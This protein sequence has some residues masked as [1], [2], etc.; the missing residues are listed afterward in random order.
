[1]KKRGRLILI[2]S[3]CLVGVLMGL[4]ASAEKGTQK[5]RGSYSIFEETMVDLSWPEV[6]QAA[7]DGAII[8]FPTAVIE[9]HGPHM[10]IGV[11]TYEAYMKCKLLRRELE[12]RGIY[13]LIAPPFYWGI[14]VAT[15]AW[16]GSFTSRPSTVQAVLFDALASLRKWG[17]LNVFFINFHG[18]K[19]H[20]LAICNAI[21]EARSATGVKAYYPMRLS[22]ARP[23]GLTAKE[24]VLMEESPPPSE[25]PPSIYLDPHAGRS[26][27]SM[28]AYYFPG[29]VDLDLARKLIPIKVK[30][31][32]FAKWRSGPE[33]AKQMT[34]LG[35]IDD[36]ASFDPNAGR[37]AMEEGVGRS[38][39]VIESFI[40]GTYRPP[41]P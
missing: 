15:A 10:G 41:T 14:N 36:P 32:D 34:P 35:Y 16:A 31:D 37:K 20:T 27:T 28:M 8:L 38:A 7:K 24:Y 26:E 29:Q 17:F 19:D 40:K 2:G 21:E 25:T 13:A 1:M 9:E 5:P 6:E 3:L 4:L 30:A 18:N 22:D 33:A 12:K 39:N 23:W 11:D